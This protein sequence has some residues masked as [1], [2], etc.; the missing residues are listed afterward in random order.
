MDVESQTYSMHHMV[1][2]VVKDQ[3]GEAQQAQWAERVV[4]AVARN[5]L[6]QAGT[7]FWQ[8]GQYWEAEPLWKRQLAIC[9]RVL[10]PEDPDTLGTV[11]ITWQTSTGTRAS[12]SKPS[13]STSERW[14]LTRKFL[15]NIIRM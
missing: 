15:G 14:P 12:M 5:L 3:L 9:E 11:Y 13:L 7:Y 2:E 1:Q 10:G 8:R 6:D 4:R